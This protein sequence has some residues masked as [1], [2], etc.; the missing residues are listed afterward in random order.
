MAAGTLYTYPDNFRAHKIQIAAEY[1]G[2][3]LKVV[4][5]P[6]EFKLGETNKTDA[7][8]NKFPVGKVPAFEAADGTCIFESNAIAYY[9][10]S[11]TLRGANVKDQAHVLQWTNF[12]DGEILPS[13]ATWVFPTLG[14]MQYNKQNTERA[15][16]DIK[17]VL[18]VL[19]NHLKTRTYLVGERVTLADIAVACNLLMLYKQVLEPG[20]RQSYGNVNRW[21]TTLINQK[22]FKEVLGDVQLCEK[23]A[24][25][26]AKKFKDLQG[27]GDKKEKKKEEKKKPEKKQEKKVE[28][29]PKAEAAAP[30]PA[31]K[32]K[33]PFADLPQSKFD[34]DEF[35]RTYSNQDTLTV[36]IPYFWEHFDKEGY[37]I[38][39]SEYKYPEDLK[40]T[41]MSCNL[42]AGMFQRLDKLRKNA[43]A[44]VCLFGESN[45]STIS[46]IW[47]WRGQKLAFELS[48]DWQIDYESYSWT[49]LDPDAEDTKKKVKEYFMQEGDF[50][51]QEVNQGKVFK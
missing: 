30:P 46:G 9:V 24:Q 35:K 49:K 4:S 14:I 7:F 1:S 38:W 21:F 2:A 34:M 51:G 36:A 25:F 16:Q 31:E 44:S 23:M 6:P 15:K 8:L 26:D 18:T 39:Y 11:E 33:D 19:N 41:F 17:N 37:S 28:E 48:E 5:E 10:A 40:M 13:A 43:F 45:K 50:D 32:K 3:R 20:F 12:A 47:F 42:I 27:G 22:E 29:K